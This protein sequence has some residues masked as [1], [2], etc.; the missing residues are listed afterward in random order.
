MRKSCAMRVG[1]QKIATVMKHVKDLGKLTWKVGT[2]HYKQVNVESM[3]DYDYFKY[4]VD[5]DTQQLMYRFCMTLT[6]T[7]VPRKQT[8]GSLFQKG[9]DMV[10]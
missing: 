9:H 1:R 10:T 3:A 4:Y 8:H 2:V 6:S 5:R 7:P